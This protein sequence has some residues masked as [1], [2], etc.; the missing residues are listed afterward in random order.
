MNSEQA[1]FLLHEMYLPQIRNEQR[2]TRRV[3][4]A[5]P[6]DRSGYKPDEKAKTAWELAQHLVSSEMFF[7]TGTANG[8]FSREDGAIPESIKTP[9]ELA[10]WY[11][12]AH[13]KAVERMAAIEPEA[14]TKTLKFAIFE[15]PAVCYAGMMISHS[16]HHRGQ[17]STYLRPMGS[18]IPRIYGGSA[19]EPI[20]MPRAQSQG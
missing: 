20:E 2:T 5:I 11:G 9:A 6:A 17:L 12:E 4:D 3:I 15:F 18:K 1:H 19:D 8:A 14:L 13:A 16:V 7:M 10:E